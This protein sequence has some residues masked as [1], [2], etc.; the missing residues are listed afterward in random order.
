MNCNYCNS[1][2]LIFNYKLNS[3][4][5]ENCG[6]IINENLFFN[7]NYF[8]ELNKLS[9]NNNNNK[10]NNFLLSNQIFNR[11]KKI[12]NLFLNIINI[13]KLPNFLLEIS[14]KYY[15][16]CL[17]KNFSKGIK[18]KILCCVIL[19]SIC[20]L[21]K[22]NILLI[23]FSNIIKINLFKL[24]T[25]YI[26]FIKLFD[27]NIPLLDSSLILKKL[28]SKFK[29]FNSN[30]IQ[31][32]NQIAFKILQCMKKNWL[33]EGRNPNGICAACIFISLKLNNFKTDDV[34]KIINISKKTI[35]LRINEFKQSKFALL[36][37]DE[38][39][40]IN[41]D[42]Y[43][44]NNPPSFIKNRENDFKE[45]NN[46]NKL[47]SL[48][49]KKEDSNLLTNY[50]SDVN[51]DKNDIKINNNNND[52]NLSDLND[53]EINDYLVNEDEYKIKK[54]LWEEKNKDWMIIENE[55]QLL[56][57]NN[58]KF[59]SHLININ[60]CENNNNKNKNFKQSILFNNK[61]MKMR[62][63]NKI[64]FFEDNLNN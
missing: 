15:K 45:N 35:N 64:K 5:C 16:L 47:N 25:I 46:N 20:R 34:C 40:N 36:S 48:D 59:N 28:I 63:K 30:E 62:M 37:K 24:G 6:K 21:N 23:E 51:I 13:L 57:N 39:L 49:F 43:E 60:E 54:S 56:K 50:K 33:I 14:M 19:Y 2:N 17:N 22:I 1:K 41:L 42:N 9:Y 8:T 29:N 53:D 52:E 10:F 38:L 11:E 4:L 44:E 18:S 58:N 61:F 31:Q 3:T 32:I 27:L 55:K 12:K 7:E 26:K